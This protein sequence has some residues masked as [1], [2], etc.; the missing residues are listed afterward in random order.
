MIVI[1]QVALKPVPVDEPH[2][3]SVGQL[4][5]G[6]CVIRVRDHHGLV[7]PI[8]GFSGDGFTVSE[9]RPTLGFT[10]LTVEASLP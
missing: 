4:F 5:C 10:K 7:A 8:E 3:R 9:Q 1:V 6:L 2:A